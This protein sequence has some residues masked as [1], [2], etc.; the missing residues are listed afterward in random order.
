MIN[1]KEITAFAKNILHSKKGLRSPQI[2][3]PARE[4][5]LGLGIALGIFAV[6]AYF[7]VQTYVE[8]RNIDLTLEDDGV[9]AATVYRGSLVE[10]ALG[11]FSARAAKYDN[12]RATAVPLDF[13]PP[14]EPE[15]IVA[16]SSEEIP[17]TSTSTENVISDEP[18]PDLAPLV[19]VRST[20][21]EKL[22]YT[23]DMSVDPLPL[24]QH[25]I[26]EGG[27]FNTCGSVCPAIAQV[28]TEQ[29]AY[30]CELEE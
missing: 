9:A 5:Q 12:L 4:W 2:M 3:H 30:T 11:E 13:E 7:S 23:D 27:T 10:A 16:T 28:C 1:K 15:V 14:V 18:L 19:S 17:D 8:Y 22:V 20:F 26:A 24:E 21:P 29:C 6:C 25:C